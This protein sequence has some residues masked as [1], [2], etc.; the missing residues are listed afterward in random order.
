MPES[1]QKI[2]WEVA[3]AVFTTPPE[4]RN[5]NKMKS[6]L[7]WFRQR[8]PIFENLEDGMGKVIVDPCVAAKQYKRMKTQ[9]QKK[10]E[11]SEQG[12][13]NLECDE[14]DV[15]K[16][17]SV[18]EK[19]RKR[20]MFGYVAE[21][22]RQQARTIHVAVIGENDII[23]GLEMI[24]DLPAYSTSV[25]CLES[26]ECYELDKPSFHRLI[27]KRNPET[28]EKIRR[29]AIARM[30]FRARRLE[31]VPYYGLL[32]EKALDDRMSRSTKS[33]SSRPKSVAHALIGFMAGKNKPKTNDFFKRLNRGG[34]G[35]TGM[36]DKNAA[37]A[38]STDTGETRDNPQDRRRD[39][40]DL[41]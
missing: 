8:S 11:T 27:V 21:E 17:L 13:S 32:L 34:P 26:M 29:V 18:I 10:V 36:N 40:K 35:T 15:A 20:L 22:R 41:V 5:T 31:H 3:E 7:V 12:S 1:L 14:D 33:K 23:G 9:Q 37:T 4:E 6:I 25:E 2:M 16:A 28:L 38:A 39:K 30:K 19:R 24:L